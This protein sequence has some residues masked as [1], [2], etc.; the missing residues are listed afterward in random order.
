MKITYIGHSAIFIE[1]KDK[2]ILIDPF[3]S[4]NPLAKFDN[5]SNISDIL[6]THAHQDHLGDA[7]PI[8]FQ[9]KVPITAV[10]E[11]ANYCS[12]KGAFATNPI[13]IG[14]PIEFEW[15]KATF[16][17][18][19]HTSSTADGCYGG[20]ACSILLEIEDKKIFHA[21]DTGLTPTMKMIGKLHHINLAFLPVGGHFTMG[22]DEAIL[23]TEF[24]KTKNIIPI[25]YNTFEAIKIDTEECKTK[26]P[27]DINCKM[28]SPGGSIEL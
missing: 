21:G 13:N 28:L 3:I 22:I 14:A 12:Q 5:N 10:F 16:F 1:T 18:A 9:K 26:F 20:V 11:L 6:L 15:G 24:L 25:H 17:E 7:I 19:S 4:Q 23:A 8:S 2:G 27:L